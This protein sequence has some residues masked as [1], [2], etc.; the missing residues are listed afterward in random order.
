MNILIV[1]NGFDLSHYLPT[2][3][4]HFMVAMDAIEKWDIANGEMSFDD[5]FGRD[6]WF[7]D[8]TTGEEWQ[9]KFFQNT[10]AIYNTG[11][12]KITQNHVK[13]L[14]E[15][16]INNVWYNFF[17]KH[18][19][20]IKT[21][22]D[23]EIK[24]NQAIEFTCDFIEKNKRV[25]EENGE[26]L[27][28]FCPLD[29]KD[30]FKGL[31]LSKFVFE[32]LELLGLVNDKKI[33]LRF[34]DYYQNVRN[35]HGEINSKFLIGNNPLY[36]ID[37]IGIFK[38]L[39]DQLVVFKSIFNYYL[40]QI[41]S[42]LDDKISI[43]IPHQIA[44]VEEIYS[45][46]YTNTFER[47]YG[48]KVDTFYLHG[49]HG[50]SQNIVLG[51]SELKKDTLRSLKAF[52]FTKYHQKLLLK[53]DYSF[54]DLYLKTS[55]AN[56]ALI[57]LDKQIRI[58]RGGAGQGSAKGITTMLDRNINSLAK[59]INFYIW[60]HSLDSSDEDYINDLFSFNEP[61]DE[62]VKIIVYY[63][64]DMAKFDLLNNLL[65]ILK[66]NVVEKWM[67]KEWLIFEEN[68]NIAELNN[69]E[70]VELPKIAEA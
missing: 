20:E 42:K 67:R 16:L 43:L 37:D 40:E 62:N 60:G 3:Y 28:G 18:T 9:N 5:L 23:F 54:L 53:T 65:L 64:D 58:A 8:D 31:S 69:I 36:G 44:E 29:E 70:P 13:E 15:K 55:I 27:Y 46:N 26:I 47:L 1:G 12:I 14:R 7:K 59:N 24:I 33:N 52:G 45:F 51:I 48:K 4:D 35:I 2:K 49:K 68:P 6:Y 19:N 11:K 38:F 25:Y 21:W 66:K 22:I 39:N 57:E 56:R 34:Q 63:F 10:K 30:N 41:I 32:S 50:N 17:K 61:Y